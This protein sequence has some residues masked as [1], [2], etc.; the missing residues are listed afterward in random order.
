MALQVSR[1]CMTVSRTLINTNS[2]TTRLMSATCSDIS[3][4]F[5]RYQEYGEPSKVLSVH[6]DKL[7]KPTKDQVIVKWLLAPLNPAD[8]N[9]IQGKYPSKPQLPAVPGNE[10]VG[11][12]LEVGPGVKNLQVGD[13]VVPNT[14]QSG[15]WRT[16]AT[17]NS[18]QLLKVPKE[19]GNIEASML[20]VNPCTAYRMLKDFACLKRGDS[21]IQNGGNSAVGQYVIQ[22]C[23]IW[24]ILNVSTVRDRPT[25][26]DLKEEL[27]N[28]GATEVL[29]EEEIRTSTVFK[30]KLPRP[31][32][33]LNCVG[34]KSALEI[35]RHLDNNGTMVTYGGMS[36]EPVTVPTSALIFKNVSV[37][38]FWA[39]QWSKEHLESEERQL[40]YDEL[41]Q[42]HIAKKLKSPATKLVPFSNYQEAVS[43]ALS[44]DGKTGVKYVLDMTKE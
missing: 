17:Y 41:A 36:R 39:S 16:H 43:N 8:I 29:T 26:S 42:L 9:T 34:G 6:T 30:N 40:M 44:L 12:I 18:Q 23:K 11:V 2:I 32:L 13:K 33:A 1:Y 28:L 19:L 15:T 25:I 31:K 38:G 22:L 24:G 4:K 35:L 21:V 14:G 5:L 37:K 7:A 27:I 10:G 3:S 20:N